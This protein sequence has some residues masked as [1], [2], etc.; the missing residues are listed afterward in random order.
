MATS[1][2]TRPTSAE[3]RST[4]CA[5]LA[6]IAIWLSL[7]CQLRAEPAGEI[8]L[9][10]QP[11]SVRPPVLPYLAVAG[12][13]LLLLVVGRHT[14]RRTRGHS[15]ARGRRADPP[16]QRAPV[17]RLAGLRPARGP[18]PGACRD[19]RHD[20]PVQPALLHGDGRG[21]L[22]A[23]P[24][25]G[26]P[27][28]ALMIDVDNFKQINDVHGHIVG[29]RVLTELA[30]ACREHARPGDIAGRYG[31]DEFTIMFP[32]TTSLRAT[33]PCRPAGPPARPRPRPRREAACL[34][35]QHRHRRMPARRGPA[36]PARA[37]RPG[38][39]RGQAG[40]GQLLAHLRARRASSR[41]S[42][43]VPRRSLDGS[44]GTRW[45][46]PR[47]AVSGYGFGQVRKLTTA[48][49]VL[50]APPCAKVTVPVRV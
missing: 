34:P 10:P 42:L 41:L 35:P 14:I 50:R 40:R 38:H 18:V 9:P 37:R 30:Q 28:V 29:D 49:P 43:E 21:C 2:R 3:T 11:A 39:V 15:P 20:R 45:G 6:V 5:M 22:R 23:R 7:A 47:L 32:G 19:R 33:Q 48:R 36:D 24:A 27:F 17:H 13:Y 26:Q 4:R 25:A 12:S 31:G 8:A 1:S 16:G 44:G 46:P